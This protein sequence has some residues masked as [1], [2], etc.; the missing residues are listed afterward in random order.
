[1]RDRL[2][3]EEAKL[4]S[5]KA[6]AARVV[7][8]P[9]ESEEGVAGGGAPSAV[10]GGGPIPA[11]VAVAVEAGTV[12]GEEGASSGLS[13]SLTYD[14]L[15]MEVLRQEAAL[16]PAPHCNPIRTPHLTPF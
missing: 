7:G 9:L 6:K 16:G 10:G 4:V 3:E 12:A 13:G 15:R 11:T 5:E 2:A 8:W 1:L 14:E